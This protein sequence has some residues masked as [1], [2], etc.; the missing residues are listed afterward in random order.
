MCTSQAW[1][2]SQSHVYQSG[3]ASFPDPCVP[4]RPGLIPRPMCTSQAWP[5]SQTHVYQ[6]GLA[7]FPDACVPVSPG[8]IPSP[9][10]TSQAW[11][12]SQTH[13]YQSGLA[14]F[15]DACVPVS[16]GL[17]PSPMCT[18]Q[19]WPHSQSH[20]YKSG[21]ASFPDPC[22]YFST[23]IY[24]P[25]VLLKM[26]SNLASSLP[27][28]SLP[29]KELH[30]LLPHVVSR[31]T[32]LCPLAQPEALVP[33]LLHPAVLLQGLPEGGGGTSEHTHQTAI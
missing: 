10:C 25:R 15:P 21:L 11:P 14:S 17:I 5:H 24:T 8:L 26:L 32:D 27:A 4:V 16:P 3:L 30:L 12:H 7:S 18:S 29:V 33:R 13:V 9:M 6:S 23:T 19:A 22:V 2:H 1:P 31:D 20:V 28:A